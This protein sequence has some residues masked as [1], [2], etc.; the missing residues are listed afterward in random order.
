M[1]TREKIMSTQQPQWHKGELAIQRT[2]GA[3]SQRTNPTVPGLRQAHAQRVAMSPLVAFGALDSSGR[4]WAAVW[5]GEAGFCRR[6]GIAGMEAGTD[7]VLVADAIVDARFDPVVAA[8]FGEK[9]S[10]TTAA[11]A[12]GGPD[13]KAMSALS[14]D[15]ATRDRVK[16]AGRFV[17]GSV[18]E[19]TTT[20]KTPGLA[21][22]RFA[23]EVE[24]ALGNCP[25]YLNKK[26]IVPRLPKPELVGGCDGS[27]GLPLPEEAVK[28]IKKADL[29]FIA[30]KHTDSASNGGTSMDVNHRGGSPGFMRVFR[31]EDLEHV[32]GSED[33]S[34]TVLVY[35]EYSGNRLYQTLGN[36]STDPV[37]GLVIPDFETGDV[38]YVTGRTTIL[39]PRDANAEKYL[40]RGARLA[41]R[42]DVTQARFVRDGL[43]F[44]GSVVDYSPY[45]PPAR[46]LAVEKEGLGIEGNGNAVATA[47]L[48]SRQ[49]ITP[50]IS[51]YIFR[52]TK[53]KG[54]KLGAWRPGQHVTFDFSGQLDRGYAHMRDDDPQ[55]L[56]DDFVRTFTV[57]APLD[58]AAT[59]SGAQF[60]RED[61]RPDLEIVVRR[62]GP[63]T[64]LLANWDLDT[65]S[66][67]PLEI[68]ILGFGGV[69][70]FRIPVPLSP[71][72]GGND[73]RG[74]EEEKENVFVAAGVGIT[75]LLAQAAAALSSQ[76][77]K[78]VIVHKRSSLK[79]LWSLRY[80]DL[81]LAVYAFT[82]IPG[83]GDVTTLFVTGIIPYSRDGVEDLLVK[84]SGLRAQVVQRR[85]TGDDLLGMGKKGKRKFFCCTGPVMMKSILQWT[86]GEEV[87]FESFEY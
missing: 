32:D 25:K 87:V 29:F 74:R 55:S 47:T 75:P 80:E 65:S 19:M 76:R 23:F 8:L 28:L 49:D 48:L 1:G 13:R 20:T 45:N 14:I 17:A 22:L 57:S 36:M 12:A 85:M 68:A 71:S 16:L 26:S 62:H 59:D 69:E 81:P 50:T 39:N 2:L 43:S 60:L 58:A 64:A 82:T 3:P 51:R 31:N 44:R 73:L 54:E 77:G 24:E 56:N 7:N 33:G 9:G 15:L 42:I 38:L 72:A 52:V 83:L 79:V 34:G 46:A 18:T 53:D 4:P 37:A 78:V 5:G 86:E 10:T 30:T 66:R 84:V 35:P 41:V 27:R 11:A 67:N 6:G 40:P 61:A 63:A 70:D 21:N